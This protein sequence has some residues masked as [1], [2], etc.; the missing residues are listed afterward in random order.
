MKLKRTALGEGVRWLMLAA[1]PSRI[2]ANGDAMR[3]LLD[4][5]VFS[6]RPESV[7]RPVTS[8]LGAAAA[9]S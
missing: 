9:R 2:R 4:D 3:W 7:T 8:G 5:P 6:G 1:L